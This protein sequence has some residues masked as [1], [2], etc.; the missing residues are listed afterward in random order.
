MQRCFVRLVLE[1][2]RLAQAVKE[3]E[4]FK[5][6][7]AKLLVTLDLQIFQEFVLHVKLLV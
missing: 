1:Q 7:Y 4:F 3:V 6:A 5:E 2:Q